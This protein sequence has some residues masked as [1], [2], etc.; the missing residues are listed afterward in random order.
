[1]SV[2]INRQKELSLL[3]QRFD[4]TRAEF[5]VIYGRWRDTFNLTFLLTLSSNLGIL[6]YPPEKV[7]PEFLSYHFFEGIVKN[8]LLGKCFSQKT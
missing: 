2:F 6:D 4:S 7:K 8:C 5:M 3:N 1:M